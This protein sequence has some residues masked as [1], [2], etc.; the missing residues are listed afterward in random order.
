MDFES[1]FQERYKN[2]N[3]KQR[4]AVDTVEGPLLVIAGPGSGKTELLSI[5]VANILRKTDAI[6]SSIL[7]L[8]FTDSGVKN[9]KK[10]L[11]SVIGSLAFDVNIHT[12][13][14][15]CLEM[16]HDYPD[17]FYQDKKAENIDDIKKIEILETILK[18]LPLEN[19]LKYSEYNLDLIKNLTS[20]ISHL[21]KSGLEPEDFEDLLNQNQKFIEQANPL[22]EVFFD[23]RM[24]NK[25]LEQIPSIINELQKIESTE[26]SINKYYPKLKD[27][28]LEKLN[29]SYSD[30]LEESSTKAITN[31]KSKFIE[32]NYQKNSQLKETKKIKKLLALAKIY[33][34]YQK[35]LQSE[36]FID[37]DDMVLNF[38][39]ACKKNP[40]LQYNL[41]ERFLYILVDEFQDTSVLQMEIL[42]ILT[43]NDVN[44]GKP[45]IMVVG[46]DD[47]AIYKFQ[48]A[49]IENILGFEKKFA[50]S[51]IVT[52]T[53]NYRST[54][55]ILDFMRPVILQGEERLENLTTEISKDLSSARNE[56]VETEILIN[57]FPSEIEE[58]SWIIEE[59]IKKISKGTK[60]EDIAIIARKHKQLISIAANLESRNI[61]INYN[62]NNNV[63]DHPQIQ[64]LIQ[65]LEFINHLSTQNLSQANEILPQILSYPFWEIS[66]LEIWKISRTSYEKKQFWLDTMLENNEI[67]IRNIAE[68]LL[69]I[70]K[71]SYEKN[72]QEILDIIVGNQ[73]LN[74]T[75]NFKNFYFPKEKIGQASYIDLL[76][77]LQ[78]LFQ[79]VKNYKRK[80]QIKILQ[81]LELFNLYK[82]HQ[83]PLK[84]SFSF[85]TPNEGIKLITAHSAKGLEF[86]NVFII[87]AQNDV[88]EKSNHFNQI[89]FP[90]N[91]NI[92]PENENL[93]DKLRLFY[94]A[95]SRAKDNLYLNYSKYDHKGKEKLKTRFL[96]NLEIKVKENQSSIGEI[97]KFL[98]TETFE[99]KKIPLKNEEK[100]YLRTLVENYK[101]SPTDLNKFIDLENCGPKKFIESSLLKFPQTISAP[102]AYGTSIHAALEFLQKHFIAK[103]QPPTEKEFIEKFYN[104]LENQRLSKTDL[105]KYFEKGQEKLKQYYEK[106]ISK[107]NINDI[108]E[109]DFRYQDLIIGNARVTGKIDKISIDKEMEK[110]TVTDYKTGKGFEKWQSSN[111]N[112]QLK[113][114]KYKQQL[115]FYKLL[116][117]NST[118]YRNKYTVDLGRLEF[119]D[120]TEDSPEKIDYALA[121]SEEVEKHKKL[122]EVVFKKIINLDF[123]DTEHYSPDIIGTELFIEDLLQGR[124]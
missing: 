28:F 86:E 36:G 8:T 75:S 80:E 65:I 62:K 90:I 44:E 94:V 26:L 34:E 102:L 47:Q 116:I 67:K 58:Y 78:T 1:I 115:I 60:P 7:C 108:P 35:T 87:N 5:R 57:E 111:P 95:L 6:A 105:E 37:F 39:K 22:I 109:L 76:S 11:E 79:T 72:A 81:L 21:K 73:S 31:F 118:A 121:N 103:S 46:D 61:P 40:E 68:F 117:E 123:P 43:D 96:N 71:L 82:K 56:N 18:T 42:D 14:S 48:G 3:E 23:Q 99:Q 17:Y 59:I 93:D 51:K 30:A 97:E 52:L 110:I 15:F 13:H 55:K 98:E 38:L 2:L 49:S 112:L 45:N 106:N 63:L 64:E 33:R 53:K 84:N 32:K 91:I 50:D 19:H 69:E 104:T 27:T 120:A 113:T 70:T 74:Y 4:E 29:T 124:V 89:N 114:L 9:M 107:L 101:L 41:Q 25:V 54:Q 85:N 119:I 10:R 92:D 88:W 16:I 20:A 122:I 77:S 12:F 100:N 83:Q 66:S 24:T